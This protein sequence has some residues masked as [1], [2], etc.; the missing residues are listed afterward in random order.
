MY[1]LLTARWNELELS[2]SGVR[3]SLSRLIFCSRFYLPF[4]TCCCDR[5]PLSRYRL[6]CV[7]EI[8]QSPRSWAGQTVCDP[9]LVAPHGVA[10]RQLVSDSLRWVAFALLGSLWFCGARYGCSFRLSNGAR[11]SPLRLPPSL[12][13]WTDWTVTRPAPQ[14]STP[15]QG[16][17]AVKSQQVLPVP[18]SR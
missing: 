9:R 1:P 2:A 10:A 12:T 11:S 4:G 13:D 14:L 5:L 3:S 8:R 7:S 17:Q 6:C 15:G 18:S 16:L